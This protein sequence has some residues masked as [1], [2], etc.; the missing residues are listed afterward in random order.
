MTGDQVNIAHERR[1]SLARV[2]GWV[3]FAVVGL[4]VVW[5]WLVSGLNGW[6]LMGLEALFLLA[7]YGTLEHR[8]ACQRGERMALMRR[9]RRR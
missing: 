6:M 9:P 8:A 1:L 7:V 4:V 3:V 2:A 5:F